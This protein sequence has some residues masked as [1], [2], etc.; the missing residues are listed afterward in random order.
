M[1]VIGLNVQRANG[2]GI[3]LAYPAEFCFHKRGQLAN[4]ELLAVFGAPDKM[5]RKFVG[6][7]FAMLCIHTC[8]SIT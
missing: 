5:V 2:P 6:D 7:M 4:E 8:H 3:S 1:H